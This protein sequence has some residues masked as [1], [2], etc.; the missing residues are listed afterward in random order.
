MLAVAG[1]P[2]P[3]RSSPPPS[4]PS[5]LSALGSPA[6]DG[7]PRS[8]AESE[9]PAGAPLSRTGGA[10]PGGR[11]ACSSHRGGALVAGLAG[12]GIQISTSP[13]AVDR[14]VVHPVPAQ[15][16]VESSP[17]AQRLA[18]SDG[19]AVMVGLSQSLASSYASAAGGP[20]PADGLAGEEEQR[21]VASPGSIFLPA[22]RV[23]RRSI[24]GDPEEN[25]SGQLVSVLKEA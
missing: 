8:D 9:G 25:L 21:S 5:S 23:G 19:Q 11:L 6:R 17:P 7:S 13:Q 12:A 14:I 20:A 1:S 3:P 18:G 4:P 24:G 15:A 10:G 16:S 22:W 2:S